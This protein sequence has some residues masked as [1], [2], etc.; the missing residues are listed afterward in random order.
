MPY[1]ASRKSRIRDGSTSEPAR[2]LAIEKLA[3]MAGRFPD[4]GLTLSSIIQAVTL[5]VWASFVATAYAHL[6]LAQWIVAIAMFVFIINVWHH[7]LLEV[8]SFEYV[9]GFV[10]TL[11][12]FGTG[13]IEL[14]MVYTMGA[15]FGLWMWGVT[16]SSAAPL[17]AVVIVRYK[18]SHDTVNVEILAVTKSRVNWRLGYSTVALLVTGGASVVAWSQSLTFNDVGTRGAIVTV[19]AAIVLVAFLGYSL[20]LTL[21][22][23]STVRALRTIAS[24]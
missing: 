14:F 11:I 5:G 1:R 8:L 13:A 10:D 6:I 22:W 18:A 23:R 17:A 24:F 19:I 4:I 7:I 12:F 21:Y 20:L 3:S 9:P 16:I 2:T 15:N